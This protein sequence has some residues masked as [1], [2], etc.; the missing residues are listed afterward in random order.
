MG[1]PPGSL[2]GD[3]AFPLGNSMPASV[4]LLSCEGHFPKAQA[5]I[6]QRER[7]LRAGV[8]YVWLPAFWSLSKGKGASQLRGVDFNGV[9]S[10]R[11]DNPS[12]SPGF[13]GTDADALWRFM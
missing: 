13:L 8:V 3:P 4:G 11:R 2:A 9:P 5:A 7:R 1:L 6:S 12:Q 10:V